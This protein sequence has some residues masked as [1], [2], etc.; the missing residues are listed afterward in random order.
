MGSQHRD[1][2]PS[3]P[4]H[5][6]GDGG[7]VLRALALLL[8]LGALTML[9]SF[10]YAPSALAAGHPGHKKRPVTPAHRIATAQ[11]QVRQLRPSLFARGRRHRVL[12]A[13][14]AGQTSLRRNRRCAAI[15]SVDRARS[16][17][18]SK[19]TWRSHHVPGS[20]KRTIAPSLATAARAVKA[21]AS[22][23]Q[24]V[25]PPPTKQPPVMPP[26]TTQP[27]LT[28]RQMINMP[29]TNVGGGTPLTGQPVTITNDQGDDEAPDLPDGTFSQLP[30]RGSPTAPAPDA[31][32]D[33]PSGH[34]VRS[35]A[36]SDQGP[37]NIFQSSN[38][39][40]PPLAGGEPKEPT[41]AMAHN[42]AWFTGNTADGY[43]VDGGTTWT[44]TTPSAVIANPAGLTPC[45]DQQVIYAPD[46]NLFIWVTQYWCPS[47]LDSTGTPSIQCSAVPGSNVVRFAF[48]TPDALRAAAANGT[49]NN[50]W[51]Y[52]DVTPQSVGEAAGA[53]FDYS[54]LSANDA[55]INWT[56]DVYRGKDTAI[57]TRIDLAGVLHNQF[58]M[59]GFP[60]DFHTVAAQE[61]PGQAVSNTTSYYVAAHDNATTRVWSWSGG[62]V[63][64]H[65][66]SHATVPTRNDQIIGS[67]GN[68]WNARAQGGLLGRALTAAWTGGKLIVG[69]QAGRD[70]C[71]ASCSSA[72][73]TIVHDYDH[74]A[75]ML[76]RVDTTGWNK[77]ADF[78]DVWSSALNFAWPALG[79]SSSG[80]VGLSMLA[81]ADNANPQPVAGYIDPQNFGDKQLA[82]VFAA[83]GPQP[84]N[85]P[86][87]PSTAYSGGTGDYYSLQPGQGTGSFLMPIRSID[88]TGGATN[89]DWRMVDYGH[90][91]PPTPSA[92]SVTFAA[93]TDGQN[94]TEGNPVTFVARV[95]DA[96]DGTIPDSAV[97][98]TIDGGATFYTGPTLTLS[99]LDLGTH[100][101]VV[102]ATNS[103]GIT[104]T[105]TVHVTIVAAAPNAPTAVITSPQNGKN[106]E[107]TD[108]D[109]GGEYVDVPV[110]AQATDPQNLPLTYTW[111]VADDSSPS[112]FSTFASSLNATVR[113]HATNSG[114]GTRFWDIRFTASN[115]SQS[116]SSSIRV[117]VYTG[118]CVS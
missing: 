28:P 20:V 78:T 103:Q 55:A 16:M 3:S 97:H 56:V 87:P 13:L 86:N 89:D 60:V 101:I 59:S 19:K 67:D 70:A 15:T 6:S 17:L 109:N 51:S 36:L 79:V 111:Q 31:Q 85:P 88:T 73:P 75:I 61:A 64:V 40:V 90:G 25:T 12:G 96:V 110:Q 44:L 24:K 115:G 45:C 46:Q 50:V 10:P 98:W 8:T 81:S 41:V 43:S 4:D 5:A 22:G 114:C 14:S 42:V 94:F 18:L 69:Y 113:L 27:S 92:P 72:K 84:G 99:N 71:T 52:F 107:A 80:A 49:M 26:P 2:G 95:S 74:T 77:A 102:Y 30:D 23:C 100:T 33:G 82:D 32:F 65:D 93:P 63:A 7:G 29:I 106:F 108:I 62:A 68:D 117:G 38:L 1:R 37:I 11:R 34:A 48:A 21:K 47:A 9:A 66:V 116:A 57:A 54:T 118:D 39:G 35:R 112:N 104:T 76:F 53:W 58:Q 83:S 105:A 91:Q